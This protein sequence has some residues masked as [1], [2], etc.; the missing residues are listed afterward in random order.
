MSEEVKIV[1]DET[2]AAM[3]KAISHAS[4]ELI[5]I[6]AGKAMPDML[7]SISVDYYGT[8]TPLNQV[9]NVSTPDARTLAVQPWEKAMIEPIEKAI[10]DANLGLN[11]QND[12]QIIRINIPALTEERRKDLVKQVKADAEFARITIRN[13]RKD[14][15]E[16]IKKLQK[17]GLSEDTAKDAEGQVQELTNK[18][19]AKIDEMVSKKEGEIMTI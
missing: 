7:D 15:N 1:L 17:D 4:A 14:G 8:D 13:I 12:G 19:I 9:A 3:D 18:Y 2:K 16:Q 10:R 6:R 11:P 5:K